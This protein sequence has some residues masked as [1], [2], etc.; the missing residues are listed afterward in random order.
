MTGC[1]VERLEALLRDELPLA[2]RVAVQAHVGHCPRCRHELNWLQSERALFQQRQAPDDVA[3]LWAA[4]EA[5]AQPAKVARRPVSQAGRLALSFAA[6][7]VVLVGV[8]QAL[9]VS[10][11]ADRLGA[12]WPGLATSEVAT[13][14]SRE[15]ASAGEPLCSRLPDGVGFRCLVQASFIA[16]R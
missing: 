14:E 2:E 16:T 10:A 9:V 12:G 13:L 3:E 5:R 7:L 4:L 1:T 8:S 15:S 6:M 11:P